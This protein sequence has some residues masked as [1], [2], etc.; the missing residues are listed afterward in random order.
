MCADF[1]EVA[2]IQ[3]VPQKLEQ[4]AGLVPFVHLWLVGG[5]DQRKSQELVRGRENHV[6]LQE[7]I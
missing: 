6:G 7:I 5:L 1:E 2:H 4:S 3:R